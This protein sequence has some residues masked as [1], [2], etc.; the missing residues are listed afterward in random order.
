[1]FN[2]K[3]AREI[4]KSKK[5]QLKKMAELMRISKITLYRWETGSRT[6]SD[7]DIRVIA[8]FLEIPVMEISDLKE[9]SEIK[10]NI[11]IKPEVTFNK[12][13][14]ELDKMTEE[15]GNVPTINIAALKNLKQA[16]LEYQK[17]SSYLDKKVHRYEQILDQSSAI[18]Y[19]LDSNYVLRYVNL[20]FLLMSNKFSTEDIVGYKASD[21]FGLNEVYDIIQ[22]EKAAFEDR[23]PIYNK[24][25]SIPCSNGNKT[26]LLTIHPVIEKDGKVGELICSIQDISE[27]SNLINQLQNLK[28]V[29]DLTDDAIVVQN[30]NST[31]YEYV[32]RSME[33]LSGYKLEVFYK[34]PNFWFSIIH[35]D[36]MNI[37]PTDEHIPFNRKG[38][39]KY[40]IIRKDDSIIWVESRIYMERIK[41]TGQIYRFAVIRNISEQK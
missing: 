28:N 20:A 29:M 30:Q 8:L 31:K 25:I 24:K 36:D 1:M 27:V 17:T 41:E 33:N 32:S 23:K 13:L 39:Y 38:K 12:N 7:N 21:I 16:C 19:V 34:N 14:Y 40:R 22:Y 35:P 10:S 11:R 26:G 37:P 3:K 6:P 4:R 2:Y 9:I 15:F 18:V 5:I